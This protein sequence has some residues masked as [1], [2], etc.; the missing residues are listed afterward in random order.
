MQCSAAGEVYLGTNTR[1][2][3]QIAIKKMTLS[4]QNM[5][6]LVTEIDIMKHSHHPNIVEYVDSY[7]VDGRL[8]VIR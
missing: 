6:L 3:Q 1:N 7:V 2:N 8:W 5:K 4:A